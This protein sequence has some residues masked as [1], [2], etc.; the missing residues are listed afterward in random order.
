L[1]G[2]ADVNVMVCVSLADV[3]VC[4][5]SELLPGVGSVSLPVTL[6]VFAIV[7]VAVVM[8]TRV[9][10][11]LALSVRMPRPQ[12]TVLVPVQLPWLGVAETK[13]TPA[14]KMSVIVTP[15]ALL[16]PLLVAVRV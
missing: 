3:D 13:L 2:G 1:R 8:T 4:S 11:A 5:V 10:V 6:A 12:T 9:T 14:G 16:G 15:V 7:P